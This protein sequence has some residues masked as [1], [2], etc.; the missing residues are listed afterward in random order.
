MARARQCYDYWMID[1][2][3]DIND[4]RKLPPPTLILRD[5]I[6]AFMKEPRV[7]PLAKARLWKA[8]PAELRQMTYDLLHPF[9]EKL[10]NAQQPPWSVERAFPEP[11]DMDGFRKREAESVG[12]PRKDD[13]DQGQRFKP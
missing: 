10:C 11:P 7:D 9:F 13:V 8:L 4:R 1:T 3:V 6:E 2:K 12:T 5:Q